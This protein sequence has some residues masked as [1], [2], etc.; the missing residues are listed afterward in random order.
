M[1]ELIVMPGSDFEI[2]RDGQIDQNTGI[3]LVKCE[4][5]FDVDVAPRRQT[6]FRD[7]NVTFWRSC[8]VNNVRT[9]VCQ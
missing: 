1:A 7:A 6:D 8:D 3:G 4:W 2:L 5:L 9:G